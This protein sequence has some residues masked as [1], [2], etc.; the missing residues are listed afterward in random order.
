MF[1]QNFH[2][3]SQEKAYGTM[4]LHVLA[5]LLQISYCILD[6]T[7]KKPFHAPIGFHLLMYN[8]F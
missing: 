4:V 6:I 7:S 2:P 3:V 5:H 8:F 1:S